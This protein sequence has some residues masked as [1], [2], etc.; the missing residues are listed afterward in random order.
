N[1]LAIIVGRAEVL[2]NETEDAE[3][4]RQLNVI[5]KVALDAAQ[6]VKR[7]QEFTRMR[8]ARPV[9]AIGLASIIS[10]GGGGAG[11][12]WK[13]E[14]QAKGI[15]YEVVAEAQPIPVVAGDPAEIREALTNIVFNALD[16][17][18]DGGRVALSTAVDG[19]YV[20][21]RV[22]D[23]GHGMAEDV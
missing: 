1:V 11:S 18:P 3:L 5:I 17:M 16:A 23:T 4:Q 12:R 6:T 10:E 14:R 13:D 20:L 22:T 7:I 15:Q 19:T 21:C 2:L 8:R 9:Q